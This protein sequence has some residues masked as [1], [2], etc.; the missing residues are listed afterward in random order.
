MSTRFRIGDYWLEQRKGSAVWQRAWRDANGCKQRASLGTRDFEA[1][2]VALAQWYIENAAMKNQAPADVTVATV[3]TRYL[4]QHGTELPSKD[5][6]KRGAALWREHFGADTTVADVTIGRQED[7]MRWLRTEKGYSDGYARRVLG[8]GKSALNRAWKRGEI[9][10]VPF[11][12]LPKGGEAYPHYASREQIVRLLSTD[13]PE[14]IWAYFLVRLCT[15]CRGDAARDLQVF[16]IDRSARLVRLNPPGRAQTKKYRPTVPLLPALAAYVDQMKPAS[17]VVN[18]HGRRVA[19]IKTSWRKI[20]VRA[21]LPVWFVPKT[22]R[23]TLATWL[24]QRGV[25]AWEVSGLLGHHAAGTT[26][27]YAKFDPKYLGEARAALAAIVED[28]ARD[29]P[30][31]R[32]LLAAGVSVGSVAPEN[33]NGEDP[34]ASPYQPLKVVGGTGFEP[35]TPTMSR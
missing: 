3:L 34:K 24:R 15:A 33:E 16:Q 10:Q 22:M 25:P 7:F 30:K 12:E 19:S 32:D 4:H 20:R 6:A 13:M 9:A 2:K 29:V 35:V 5:V 1:A 31:L 27:V 21:A 14:H 28:L 18:W 8:V 17:Y 23:H 26:D 11:V